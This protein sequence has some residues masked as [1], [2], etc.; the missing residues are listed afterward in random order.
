MTYPCLA[1]HIGDLIISTQAGDT[2]AADRLAREIDAWMRARARRLRPDLAR[3]GLADEMAQEAHLLLLTRPAGHYEP[4]RGSTQIYLTMLL[5][6]AAKK[7]DAAYAAPG[8]T[9][10]RAQIQDGQVVEPHVD[11]DAKDPQTADMILETAVQRQPQ[12]QDDVLENL[13]LERLRRDLDPDSAWVTTVVEGVLDGA[14]SVDQIAVP[15][16]SRF[17]VRRR[18]RS[19]RPLLLRAGLLRK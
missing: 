6:N 17:A 3:R 19:C 13:C 11:L 10:R 14:T 9:V 8:H 15:G 16:V 18:T 2:A 5:R 4:D 7:V 12:P 1:E